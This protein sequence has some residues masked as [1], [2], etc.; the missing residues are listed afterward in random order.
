MNR[1]NY[2]F[3]DFENVQAVDLALVA[4]KPVTVIF[5][6]GGRHRTVPV[7]MVG[8]L[9]GNA[10]QVRMVRSP[11]AGK[12][13]LDFVLACQV[14]MYAARDPKGF[15]HILSKD[16][17]FDAL[18]AYLK[19]EGFHAA[20]HEVFAKIPVLAR[21]AVPS[22]AECVERFRDHLPANPASR[23]KREKAL[24]ALLRNLFGAQTAEP[25]Q[26]QA[27]LDAVVTAGIL[28]VTPQGAVTYRD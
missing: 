12:N 27:L 6:L 18:V 5:V 23:P 15:F 26:E 25:A 8:Q 7:E 22:L 17:G 10:S 16:K 1:A 2:I 3:V 9:L 4:G 24:R 21:P 28:E 13:A 20:R 11:Q 19:E 14:G